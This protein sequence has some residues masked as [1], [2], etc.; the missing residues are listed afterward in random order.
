MQAEAIRDRPLIFSAPMIRALL[1]GRKSQTRRILKNQETWDRI[2]AIVKRFPNQKAGVPYR[3]GDLLWVR[4]TFCPV[5]DSQFG[6]ARWIDYRATPKYESS[7]PAGWHNAPD[8]PDALKWRSCMFMPRTASRLTLK[9][10]G[11]KVER[12]LDISEEDAK[13]EGFEAGPLNDGF[14]PRDFGDG[15]TVE[16]PGGWASAAGH[17][18]ILWT[19]LHPDWDGYSSPWVVAIAFDVFKQNIDTY[20][21]EQAA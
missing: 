19:K 3:V 15:W 11:V 13:A 16:S 10:T 9:V 20:L 5:D 4:E 8:D 12:L 1:G 2:D 14:G 21:R 7:H 6:E 17:F 18:Q